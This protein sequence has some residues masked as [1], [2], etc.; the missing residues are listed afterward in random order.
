M[1][2]GVDIFLSYN[3]EEQEV[4]LRIAKALRDR[5]IHV[6]LDVWNL[7]P[8]SPSCCKNPWPPLREKRFATRACL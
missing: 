3:R 8:G 6:W 7:V 5:R 2:Q 4:V 1:D